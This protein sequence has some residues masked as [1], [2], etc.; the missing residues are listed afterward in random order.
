MPLNEFLRKTI[1]ILAILSLLT[2][3]LF[4]PAVFFPYILT[5]AI[6]FRIIVEIMAV[7]YLVLALVD[8]KYRPVLKALTLAAIIFG[9]AV[10][11]SGVFGVNF[12]SSFWSTNE[13]MEGIL[14]ISHFILWFL[15]LA[16]TIKEPKDFE[17]LLKIAVI[18]A[19]VI[20]FLSFFELT[21]LKKGRLISASALMGY[22]GNPSFFGVYLLINAF[23]ALFLS[24]KQYLAKKDFRNSRNGLLWFLAFLALS[25]FLFLTACRGALSGW[26]LGLLVSLVLLLWHFRKTRVAKILASI[27][28][29]FLIT[30]ISLFFLVRA[31][32]F[33]ANPYF[34]KWAHFSLLDPSFQSRLFAARFSFRAFLDRP[35]FGWG[36]DNFDLI[37][38][39]YYEPEMLHYN[40]EFYFDRPHN[41]LIE[42]MADNG[43]FGLLSYLFLWVSI[44]ATLV[45]IYKKQKEP[46]QLIFFGLLVG[47]FWQNLFL[48][49]IFESYLLFFLVLAYLFILSLQNN[50]EQKIKEG[51][52]KE[53]RKLETLS[54]NA[55]LG[56]WL[57]LVLIP[58]A[59]FFGYEL[60]LKPYRSSANLITSLY[61]L[62]FGQGDLAYEKSLAIFK[63]NTFI[64]RE[65]LFNLSLVLSQKMN[66]L[67]SESAKKL[68]GLYISKYQELIKQFPLYSRLYLSY[69]DLMTHF[70]SDPKQTD[71]IFQDTLKRFPDYPPVIISYCRF[72]INQKEYD[73]VIALTEP[74]IKLDPKLPDFDFFYG[75]ALYGRGEK[76]QGL[77][78]MA[79]AIA[80]GLNF[81][82]SDA[83]I[84]IGRLFIEG[85]RYDLALELLKR[86]QNLA[87][88]NAEIEKEIQN[89][90][91]LISP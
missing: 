18:G 51:Q 59:L 73:K 28:V 3:F 54:F 38:P 14:G 86:A 80:K 5:K 89:L 36:Q 45:G 74:F 70:S 19:L 33:S 90:E 62:T 37:F 55:K 72:L 78:S 44:F 61:A 75:Y 82:T 39:Q 2:C 32:L 10:F 69:A 66:Q 53:N 6:Y 26:V 76:V 17:L 25:V 48:F 43:A 1:F 88:Q 34:Q 12:Y 83:L 58:L 71:L 64:N 9:L 84:T 46:A 22:T 21:I 50:K 11:L 85:K 30:L 31:G 60:N 42:I 57:L 49:D 81:N 63:A 87:P 20:G 65:A 68:L 41:K 77:D 52:K 79:K 47:Y 16:W 15:I 91:S 56:L 23:L 67:D 8:K 13:R 7:L 24:L 35:I 4:N 27:L 40:N 29:F